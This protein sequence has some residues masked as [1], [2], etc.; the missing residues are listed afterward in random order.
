MRYGYF[1]KELVLVIIILFVGA[2]VVP[3]V[4]GTNGSIIYVDDGGADYICIQDAIDNAADGDTI[5]VFNRTYNENIV[6][7]KTIYLIG[8]NRDSTIIS[9]CQIVPLSR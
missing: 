3:M 9:S 6:I 8:E 5:Y 7:D 1:R 2:S 4:M